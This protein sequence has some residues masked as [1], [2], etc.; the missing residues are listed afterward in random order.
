MITAAPGCILVITDN[1]PHFDEG[2]HCRA[3]LFFRGSLSPV[4]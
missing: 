1:C 3:L 4:K 2:L